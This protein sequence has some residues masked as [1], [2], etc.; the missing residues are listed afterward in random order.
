MGKTHFKADETDN[1][2]CYCGFNPKR[3]AEQFY[4]VSIKLYKRYYMIPLQKTQQIIPILEQ[5]QWFPVCFR[6]DFKIL[7]VTIKAPHNQVSRFL[8]EYLELYTPL[9]YISILGLPFSSLHLSVFSMGHR[10]MVICSDFFKTFGF[11]NLSTFKT[12]QEIPVVVII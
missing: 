8:T 4:L 5:F 7:L 6:M 12:S 11:N 1:V 9:L 2:E 3:K 10:S